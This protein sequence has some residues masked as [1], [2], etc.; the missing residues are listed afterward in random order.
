MATIK[1][2]N[3]TKEP[4]YRRFVSDQVLTATQL[5]DIVDHFERQDRLSRVCLNGVGI[6]CGLQVNYIE[7]TSVEVTS[8]CAVTTDGDLVYFEGATYTGVKVFEDSDAKYERLVDIPLLELKTSNTLEDSGVEAIDTVPNLENRVVVLYL[9]YYGKDETP[10]TSTDCD[11]QGQEQ[12]AKIRILL[13]SKENA[14]I[15]SNSDND[16]IFSK[17]NNTKKFHDLPEIAIRR[18]ILQNSYITNANRED[19]ISQNSNTADYARL[20]E[21]YLKVI[22]GT[23]ILAQLKNGVDKLFNEFG[24]LLG[25]DSLGIKSLN[26]NTKIDK[27]FDFNIKNI[28]I[29]IQYRYD[30]LLDLVDTYN[31]IKQLIF[32]VRV[33]CC[34]D[35]NAF[36]KH[37]LLGELVTL[38]SYLQFRHNFYPSPIIPHGEEKLKKMSALLRRFH[39][40]VSEYEIPQS[41]ASSIKVTPSKKC[42]KPLGNR[43]IPYYYRGTSQLIE[44]WD[45][46]KTR[47]FAAED[48]LGYRTENLSERDAIQNPLDYDISGNDFYRIEGHLGKDYRTALANLDTIKSEKGL[49]FEIKVLSIDETLDR[50]NPADY[51]CEFDDLNAVLKAWRAEQNCL[52]ASISKFFSGFSL[53][54]QGLHKYYTLNNARVVSEASSRTEAIKTTNTE[55]LGSLLQPRTTLVSGL[56][57]DIDVLNANF[58]NLVYERDTVIEDNLKTDEDVLGKFIDKA[59]KEKPEG[60]A[61]DIASIVKTEV[62]KDSEISDWDAE[63]RKVAIEQPYEILAYTKVATRFIPNNVAEMDAERI[64]SYET[65]VE[66]LCNRVEGF[67]KSMTSLLFDKESKYVRRGYEEQYALLLNQLS[68]NCCAAEKMKVLFEE[69]EERKRKILEQKLLSK[70]VEKHVGLEHRAGVE[71]GGT[72]VM[73]YKGGTQATKSV[74]NLTDLLAK[75][76]VSLNPI[77]NF[78]DKG[79]L[80]E[81]TSRKEI[82]FFNNDLQ[83][84]GIE[85]LKGLDSN[86]KDALLF[87]PTANVSENTV[88]ADFAL[89]YIC[90]SDCSPVAFMVPKATVSLRLPKDFVC[91]DDETTPIAFEV[92]P[93]DG[94]V[95]AEVEEGLAGGVEQ[96]DG[97]FFFNASLISEELLG[98][99]IKFTVNGQ[100]TDAK[101]TVF[102]KPVFDFIFSDP[103]FFKDNT[104]ALVN[105]TSQIEEPSEGLTYFW[106]FGDD[107]LPENNTDENPRHEYELDFSEKNVITLTAILTVTNGKCSHS[108][109][110]NIVFEPEI[111]AEACIE[112]TFQNIKS[113]SESLVKF[114]EISA[115]IRKIIYNPTVTLYKEVIENS[116]SFLSGKLNQDLNSL[117]SDLMKTTAESILERS[118]SQDTK[119]FAAL[120]GIYRLQVQLFYNILCCQ[121]KDQ[122]EKN[123]KPLNA[124]L[125][126]IEDTLTAFQKN[127]IKID[128]TEEL[129][130]F[131]NTLLRKVSDLEL[132]VNHIQRQL[133]L[134]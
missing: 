115:D 34:P 119:I 38:E 57:L 1:L 47:K 109:T 88:I 127:K 13:M 92:S 91:L 85:D 96:T 66:N 114:N 39:L 41:T 49:P 81:T 72:F 73:V 63:V 105:F 121:S 82:D 12:I 67:K 22:Q 24:T 28:P 19:V 123:A 2:N 10:C 95:T 60:S 4:P 108:T 106:D 101:I 134:L 120:T 86:L 87:R 129:K 26:I 16:P 124:F 14:E 80:V 29:D 125:K 128:E 9:E 7:K 75:A 74:T 78:L 18:V 35:P 37:L 45:Y 15:I 50:I 11:T 110:H 69:I 70:F 52:N 46:E 21:S 90:C 33:A 6:V 79:T 94:I 53:K 68:V 25:T 93:S 61:V 5:N 98:Q 112:D 71:P 76:N 64:G 27:L 54:E 42:D 40:M 31:E 59:I 113:D 48:N 23:G 104:K 58:K 100:F 111:V 103:R 56:K 89:P 30:L 43:S 122:I 83:R 130:G 97:K 131:L 62:E 133:E 8:G 44:Y 116:D 36:P 99:E 3:E 20:K 102:K 55:N 132:L 107:T 117:F 118:N 84:I 51:D 126:G 17:F 65:T 32:D 77:T